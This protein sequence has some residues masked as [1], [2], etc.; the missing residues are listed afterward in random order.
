M[1]L[2][3]KRDGFMALAS[4][5]DSEIARAEYLEYAEDLESLMRHVDHWTTWHTT[6]E[7]V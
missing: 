7:T 5:A 1:E 3:R 6:K 4:E 2:Q